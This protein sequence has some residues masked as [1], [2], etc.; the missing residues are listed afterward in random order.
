MFPLKPLLHFFAHFFFTYSHFFLFFF[1]SHKGASILLPQ[2]SKSSCCIVRGSHKDLYHFIVTKKRAFERTWRSHAPV[3]FQQLNSQQT[4]QPLFTSLHEYWRLQIIKW[5]QTTAWGNSIQME[6]LH[7][8]RQEQARKPQLLSN[9]PRPDKKPAKRGIVPL[10]KQAG[11]L[12][13]QRADIHLSQAASHPVPLVPHVGGGQTHFSEWQNQQWPRHTAEHRQRQNLQH[14]QSL[15]W[16]VRKRSTSEPVHSSPKHVGTQQSTGPA[17]HQH[18]SMVPSWA[19]GGRRGTDGGVCAQ[20]WA[21][22][23]STRTRSVSKHWKLGH[24]TQF[25]LEIL[26]ENG[27]S[28]TAGCDQVRLL[29]QHLSLTQQEKSNKKAARTKSTE[30]ICL[31]NAVEFPA[32]KRLDKHLSRTW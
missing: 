9:Q 14:W 17:Q 8:P 31:R 13:L 7:S 20:Q 10:L 12:L 16:A 1:P 29:L 24:K 27:S 15:V 18:H 5:Q 32:I 3:C 2:S 21:G 22:S 23:G 4:R 19:P 26:G 11:Q 28:E 6:G 30:I 25:V